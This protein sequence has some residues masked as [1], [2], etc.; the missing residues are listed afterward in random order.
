MDMKSY[1]ILFHEFLKFW[2]CLT[3]VA[4]NHITNIF[5]KVSIDGFLLNNRLLIHN[6]FLPVIINSVSLK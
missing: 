1:S 4:N 6:I 3:L 5:Q 2:K